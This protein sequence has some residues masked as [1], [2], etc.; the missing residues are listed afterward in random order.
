MHLDLGIIGE[1]IH[2]G[3]SLK[4]KGVVENNISDRERGHVLGASRSKS[5]KLI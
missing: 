5:R 3:K 1:I 2:E 4:I